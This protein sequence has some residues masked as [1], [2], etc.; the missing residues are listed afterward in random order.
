[1][2]FL[3]GRKKSPL[4]HNILIKKRFAFSQTNPH[5]TD[6]P[7]LCGSMKGFYVNLLFIKSR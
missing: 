4:A 1:M 2:I 5:I 7:S 6:F 3:C